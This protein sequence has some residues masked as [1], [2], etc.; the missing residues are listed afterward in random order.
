MGRQAATSE[1]HRDA[2][3]GVSGFA[4]TGQAQ[5]MLFE[6]GDRESQSRLDEAVDGI[7]EQ[8]GRDR[9]SR[10]SDLERTP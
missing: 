5:Q 9:L 3:V 8:F 1:K 6:D 7:R 2:G 10:G 4:T